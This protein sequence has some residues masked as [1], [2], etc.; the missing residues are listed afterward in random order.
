MRPNKLTQEQ[1]LTRCMTV[2][3]A[4][5]YHGTSMQMLA[6]ACGLTKGAF[7]YHYSD[8]Q[9]LVIDL[10]TYLHT[11]LAQHIFQPLAHASELNNHSNNRLN[12]HSDSR[13]ENNVSNNNVSNS[14][15]LCNRPASDDALNRYLATHQQAVSFFSQGGMGCLMSIL[16]LDARH[17]MPEI[18]H[19]A[20]QFFTHW[21]DAMTALYS[22]AGYS[23]TQ[24]STLA[25]QAVADYEGAILLSALM[26]DH[27]Y[28]TLVKQRISSQLSG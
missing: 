20:Q 8:K 28:L 17:D 5:G 11:H 13:S 1:L 4:H 6:D 24:A 9:Q 14:N 21:Q 2:F 10:L 26:Q 16:A 19:I 12:H 3:K 22:S 15:A 27:S 7:Y 25:K 18:T 23:T